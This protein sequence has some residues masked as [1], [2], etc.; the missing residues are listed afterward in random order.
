MKALTCYKVKK[1]IITKISNK[2]CMSQKQ[3]DDYLDKG[4][5]I[6]KVIENGNKTKITTYSPKT[7]AE[8]RREHMKRYGILPF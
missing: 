6:T 7:Y 3:I 4:F 5:T 8:A 1:G 2:I